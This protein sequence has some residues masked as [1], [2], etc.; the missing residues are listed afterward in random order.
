MLLESKPTQAAKTF[1]SYS[2]K[3]ERYKN[4]LVDHLSA[5]TR[6]GLIEEWDDREIEAG[7]EWE[8]EVLKHFN[9]ADI[10]LCLISANFISSQYCYNVEMQGALD[11]RK[12]GLVKVIPILLKE[13]AWKNTPFHELQMIPRDGQAILSRPSKRDQVFTKVVQD[14]EKV[15]HTL[16]KRNA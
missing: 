6:Q 2:R 9:E 1:L 8:K 14:I 12:V 3:D 5:L 4:Y 11:R 7:E 13:C 15:V 16:N 10:I